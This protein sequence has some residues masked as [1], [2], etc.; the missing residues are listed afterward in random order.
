MYAS[1]TVGLKISQSNC[2]RG[3]YNKSFVNIEN[4]IDMVV[5]ALLKP[6]M[7]IASGLGAVLEEAVVNVV[8]I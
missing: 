3:I 8:L 2:W 1:T 6:T 7:W 5:E 4:K